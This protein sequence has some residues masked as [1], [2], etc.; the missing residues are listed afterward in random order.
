MANRMFAVVPAQAKITEFFMTFKDYPQRQSV[1]SFS[2]DKVLEQIQA[3]QK[4]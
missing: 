2:L 1:G 4:N 3:S